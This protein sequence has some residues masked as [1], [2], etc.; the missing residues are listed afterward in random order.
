MEGY[1]TQLACSVCGRKMVAIMA[2]IG[3]RHQW[4]ADIKCAE[5]VTDKKATESKPST[6]DERVEERQQ[7]EAAKAEDPPVDPFLPKDLHTLVDR[8]WVVSEGERIIREQGVEKQSANLG[9]YAL[10]NI[11]TEEVTVCKTEALVAFYKRG[12]GL[13]PSYTKL[14]TGF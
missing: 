14:L 9:Q 11:R 13:N 3:S 1:Y 10:V 6:N 12:F 8:Y 5:C 7:P 2:S 4:V